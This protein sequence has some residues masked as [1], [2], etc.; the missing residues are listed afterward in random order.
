[1]LARHA[2]F[3][4]SGF[5]DGKPVVNFPPV[6]AA[7]LGV[8]LAV[9]AWAAL[10]WAIA[11][12]R[13]VP[14]RVALLAE[15]IPEALG[16]AVLALDAAG[17]VGHANSAAGRLVGIPVAEL[18]D[19]DVAAVVP[20]LAALARGAERGPASA[21]ISVPGPRGPARVRAVVLRVSSRPAWD[22]A[23]LRPFPVTRPRPPPLPRSPPAPWPARG[24]ARAGFA[25]AA[26]ALREPVAQAAGAVSILRLAAP[27]LGARGAFALAEAEAALEIADRRVAALAA[28]G[29]GGVRRVLDL[30]ALAADLVARFPPPPGVRVRTGDGAQGARALADDRPVRAALRELLAAA[31][32]AAG[33]GGGE[34]V[35]GVRCGPASV[36]IEV[37]SPARVPAGGLSLARALVAPQ[38]GRVEEEPEPGRGGVVRIALERAASLEPA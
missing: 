4:K 8:V 22:L 2:L 1:V 10:R 11:R 14:R 3:H 29:E 38:G 30:G 17:R 33:A 12:R 23:V 20:E 27:A 34:L 24:E 21:R 15:A 6:R 37:R 7:G 13:A 25:A 28:A 26:A 31:A 35:V 16:D 32:A 9:V 36:A 5:L 19:R 18:V